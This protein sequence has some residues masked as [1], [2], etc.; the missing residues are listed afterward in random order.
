MNTDTKDL[1]NTNETVEETGNY[2]CAAGE[3]RTLQSGQPFPECPRTYEPTTW[4]H[5]EHLHPTGDKVT[6]A[7]QYVD[8]DGQEMSFGIGQ[9]FPDC[10]KTGQ[11]TLWKHV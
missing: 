3:S 7:G 5:A 4:R 11:D 1:H 2:I 10:P 6:E 9:V 8:E